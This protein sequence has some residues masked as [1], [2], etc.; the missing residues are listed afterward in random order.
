MTPEDFYTT[1]RHNMV[2]DQISWRGIQTERVLEALRR[3]PRHLFIPEGHRS[4]AYDDCPLP[5]G[6]GQTISQPYIVALM[7]DL[8]ELRGSE[9]VLE[10]GTGSGYQAAVLACLAREVHTIERHASLA[11][12][13]RRTLETLELKNVSIHLGDG[14][15][16]LPEQA[17]FDAM[18][19]T[20]AAPSVPQ[21]LLNQLAEGARLVIPV[22]S[23]GG[24]VLQLWQRQG[25]EFK[26]SRII[27]VAFVPL[28]GQWGWDNESNST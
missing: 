3:I 13:A 4:Q 18:L 27:S 19:V 16:G 23:S 12:N 20:A 14:S 15:L 26:H 9:K 2:R 1:L 17:P 11:E 7:S 10:V 25:A 21:P 24:Q 6:A 8:L 28:R 5:I 22:G